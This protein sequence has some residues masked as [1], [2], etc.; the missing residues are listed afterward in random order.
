MTSIGRQGG[1]LVIDHS[2][3]PGI[4]ADLAE[5][6]AAKGVPVS[7]GS[8]TLEMDSWCCSHCNKVVL[9]NPARKRPR[10]VCRKCMHV[11]C[12]RCVNDCQPFAEIV[13]RVTAGRQ[14][15][16]DPN[17]NLLLPVGSRADY[18]TPQPIVR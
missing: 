4:P 7:V 9:K 15:L 6:W 11:V 17:T 3:S 13:E 10:E 5:K 8:T 16:F 2:N 12:D 18:A 1:Y 14:I